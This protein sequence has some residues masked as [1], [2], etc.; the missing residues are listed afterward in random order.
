[1]EALQFENLMGL[2][3]PIVLTSIPDK[4]SWV[5]GSSGTFSVNTIRRQI[6]SVRLPVGNIAMRWNKY[7]PIKVN[8]F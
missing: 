1:M 6:D 8:I 7:V 3:R 4:W 2:L 5:F